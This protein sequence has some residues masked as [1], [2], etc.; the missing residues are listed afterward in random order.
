MQ[1]QEAQAQTSNRDMSRYISF[2]SKGL[3]E[4]A[5]VNLLIEG[6]A[7]TTTAITTTAALPRE[8]FKSS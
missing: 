7:G 5:V 4:Y 6:M 1:Q 2:F 3:C 8:E